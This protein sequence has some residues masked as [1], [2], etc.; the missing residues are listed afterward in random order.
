MF[1]AAFGKGHRHEGGSNPQSA[2]PWWSLWA[3]VVGVAIY[4]TWTAM[5]GMQF[6]VSFFLLLFFLVIAVTT[7]RIVAATGLLWLHDYFVPMHGMSVV[8]GSARVDPRT[9]T[10]MG[11]VD[12]AVL[13]NRANIMPQLLDG[14]KIARQT[15]IRQWHYFVGVSLGIV[16]AVV[17]SF[18][19]VL[20][21]AYTYGGTNLEP[22][23]F[24]NGGD[25]LFN[26][27]AGFQRYHVYTHW[28]AVGLM[29]AGALFMSALLYLHRTFLWWPIYPLGFLIGDTIASNQIWFPVFL[30]WVIKS[31][32]IRFSGAAAYNRLK[33]GALGLVLGEF[34]CVGLWL[35]I[36]GM[37]GVTLHRVFPK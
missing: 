35:V 8:V 28:T 31:V 30:G 21:L 5:T 24:F 25:W 17:V 6:A 1:Y 23:H 18:A 3:F 10:N 32:I 13:S 22:W 27:T 2:I 15:S 12:F 7:A 29:G 9:W 4:F 26:R 33:H 37:T 34:L 11:F 14:M 20:W 19:T 16:T 36:D